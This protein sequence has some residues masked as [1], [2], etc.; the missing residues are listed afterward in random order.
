[1]NLKIQASEI[2]A[3]NDA[4]KKRIVVN[5]GGTSSGKT[6]S[7]LQLLLGKA[8]CGR[9]HISV[10]SI[11]LPHL[12]KGAIKDFVSILN[13]T[14]LYNDAMHNKTDNVFRIGDSIIEFFALDNADK[15]RGPRRD[16]L[17]VNECN[18]VPEDTFIQ[19]LLR[20]KE[21]I[22]VDYNP[23]DE[24]HWIYEH[25][26]KRDDVDFIQSTY[27][28]NPFLDPDIVKEIER[29][30]D[31][32]ENL[33]RVYGLGERGQIKGLIYPQWEKVSPDKL[34][35]SGFDI[36]YGLDFGF[37]VPTALVQVAVKDGWVYLN[38]LL[39]RAGMTNGDLIQFL[40]LTIPNKN[41]PIYADAAEPQR[42]EEIYR[43]GFNIKPASKSV[44][45]GIDQVKR[46]RILVT[47]T[48]NNI[49]KERGSYKWM[50]DKEGHALDE[51]VKY[52]DHI[53]DAIRY[54][55]FSH[56]TRPTGRY[57]IG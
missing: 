40:N 7:I 6:Y 48:S 39:Y 13:S 12:K 37:N 50:E 43:A 35:E 18:L 24:T 1:M 14:G 36:F 28:D 51:P 32:D 2:L 54:A 38:E 33:W 23:A 5:Q 25:L 26:L 41:H 42:I 46:Q 4:S 17:F 21:Q 16:I 44:K 31:T 47:E 19:L 52:M 15:A 30:K 34:K 9:K 20:T 27:K 56:N 29:L 8:L 22:F 10:C 45:D 53:M 57:V 3:R 11:N 55:I 49:F